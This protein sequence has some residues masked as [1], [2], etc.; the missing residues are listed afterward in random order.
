MAND[1]WIRKET[2]E[3]SIGKQILNWEEWRDSRR[4][5]QFAN[6]YSNGAIFALRTALIQ[7]IADHDKV[8]VPR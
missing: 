7:L 2:V 1:D 8:D 5:D 4:D 3:R 6:D